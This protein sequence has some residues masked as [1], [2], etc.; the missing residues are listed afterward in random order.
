MSFERVIII[1]EVFGRGRDDW[2]KCYQPIVKWRISNKSNID[3]SPAIP[4]Q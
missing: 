1:R 3:R 4:A 2:Q